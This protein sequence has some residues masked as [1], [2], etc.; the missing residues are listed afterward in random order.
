LK[1]TKYAIIYPV[2]RE[3]ANEILSGKNVFCKYVGK[4]VPSLDIGSRILLY[5]SHSNFEIVGEGRILKLEFM[6]PSEILEKHGE[7][8]FLSRKELSEY[9]GNRPS[10]RRLLV[11]TLSNIK[12]FGKPIRRSR[13]IT[14]AGETLT[15]EQYKSLL[16]GMPP[17]G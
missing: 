13:P 15:L 1:E 8:L 11:A 10:D 12:K 4:G 6:T 16:G 17:K 2:L 9:Q 5:V 14:M 3:H 7:R